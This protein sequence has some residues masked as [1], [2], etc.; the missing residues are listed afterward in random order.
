MCSNPLPPA[1]HKPGSVG[2]PQGV[3]LAILNDK[4]QRVELG[5]VCV[6]GEN[7]TSGYLNNPEAN[8]SSF[9][10]IYSSDMAEEVDDTSSQNCGRLWFR[11]GDQGRVD[12]D[13][14]LFLTG[15]IKE[16]INRGGEK[17]SPLEV[18]AVLLQ[19]PEVS[20]AVCFAVD[21]EMYGQ[22]VNAA[23]VLKEGQ[24]LTEADIQDYVSRY[25]AKFKVPK[26]V[27]ITK[28]F[29]KTA[30]GK[31]QRRVVSDYFT[32]GLQG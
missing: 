19:I 21:D 13:G 3:E 28:H 23:V 22:E 9:T 10:K 27:F 26:R 4:G 6:R 1:T 25:L 12:A 31:I 8:R 18:D 14:Y 29:P 5:E 24:V 2:I 30:T 20:E 15:R 11:T 17:I 7:V 16:L 32:K